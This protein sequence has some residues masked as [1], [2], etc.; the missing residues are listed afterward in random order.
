MKIKD[1]TCRDLQSDTKI[2]N[3]SVKLTRVFVEIS[4]DTGVIGRS[5][6][7]GNGSGSFIGK[8]LKPTLIGEDPLRIEMLWDRLITKLR[9]VHPYFLPERTKE[10]EALGAVDAALWDLLGKA[11]ET[12]VYKLVGGYRNRI[13]V[14]GDGI[15]PGCTIDKDMEPLSETVQ[16]FVKGGYKAVKFHQGKTKEFSTVNG[17]VNEIKAVRELV[18]DEVELMSD[19]CVSW[20]IENAIKISHELEK[21]HVFWVEDPV[22]I[23]DYIEGCAKVRASTRI[24]LTA[25]EKLV[26]MYDCRNLI[27]KRA[28]DI[29]NFCLYWG[30]TPWLKVAGMAHLHHIQMAGQGSNFPEVMSQLVAGVP[31]GLITNM[32]PAFHPFTK[33]DRWLELYKNPIEA[34]DGY[35]DMPTEPG[36]GVEFDHSAIEKFTVA[37][38]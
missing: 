27:E 10:L 9:A 19:G 26:T 18:G 2:A 16:K 13:P 23:E 7:R 22:H 24:P 8:H 17:V 36:F 30:V 14:Y 28:V 3:K 31:N 32:H 12:P 20:T 21:Y 29:I 33:T 5:L 4:T 35:L 1:V 15:G 37:K 11:T 34:K 25:G 6:W 38:Y